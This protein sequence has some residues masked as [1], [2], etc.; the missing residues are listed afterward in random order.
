MGQD[1]TPLAML[2]VAYDPILVTSSVLVAIMASFTG[3]RLASGLRYHSV[4]VRKQQ[5]AK[6]AIALG[7]GIW[8]MHFV[9]MLAVQLPVD[10]RYEALPTLGSALIAILMTGLGLLALHFGERSR[11]RIVL[12]G[13]MTGL[14]I[15]AMHYIGMSAISGNCIVVFEG[16]GYVIAGTISVASS[17]AAFWMAYHR[18]TVRQIVIGA[19][20]LGL[21]VSAVHYSAMVYTNFLPVEV[22]L[23]IRAP[24]LSTGML[25][26]IV[27]FA[28]F[29]V[30]GLFLFSTIPNEP[31]ERS[32]PAVAA[33]TAGPETVQQDA[34]PASAVP[35]PQDPAPV[36]EPSADE[37]RLPV[38]E[39]GATRFIPVSNIRM[40]RADG[41]YTWLHDGASER[42]CPRSISKLYSDLKAA[43][44]LQTH[45]SYLASID[46]ITGFER[47]GEKTYCVIDGAGGPRIPVSRSRIKTVRDALKLA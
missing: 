36:Q 39:K 25:A 44:F 43:G 47:D 16:L 33:A 23:E 45:R 21:T 18:R 1:E 34:A 15:I 6:A 7:G 37:M 40:V 28:A 24:N 10:V 27:A 5:I 3:L 26:L 19:V 46:H 14:G 8:S 22:A 12:A 29:L 4:P 9:G 38:E 32:A 20:L 41:H 2:P 31:P 11:L 30:C 13:V 17:I 42:F 35:E